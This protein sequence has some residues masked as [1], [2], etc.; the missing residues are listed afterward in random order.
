M[1][2]SMRIAALG[3]ICAAGL[4]GAF[5]GPAV[6]DVRFEGRTSQGAFAL[7]VAEDD[8][9]P[10]RGFLRWRADCRR[11]GFGVRTSTTFRRPLDLATRRRLRDVGTYRVRD[12]GGERLTV[13]ARVAGRRVGPRRWAGTFRARVV[14]RRAGRVI[15]RCGVRGVRWRVRR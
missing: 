15:D 13:T 7:L 14:V 10:K 6:A 3:S 8:G 1:M 12:R 5:A 9:V 2:R 4:L 11:P